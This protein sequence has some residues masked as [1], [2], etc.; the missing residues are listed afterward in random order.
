MATSQSLSAS[1]IQKGVIVLIMYGVLWGVGLFAIFFFSLRQRNNGVSSK[2]SEWVQSKQRA[3]KKNKTKDDVRKYLTDYVNE[4][5]PSVFH[6]KT[7]F[8]RLMDEIMKHHRYVLLVSTD[9]RIT[10][11]KRLLSGVQ[12]LTI[13]SLLMFILALMYD[14][15]VILLNGDFKINLQM[16]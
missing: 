16:T 9:G 2:E 5:F 7:A 6:S 11:S 1:S 10:D 4:I 3:A 13:Q 15:Q 8:G 14:I 12:L